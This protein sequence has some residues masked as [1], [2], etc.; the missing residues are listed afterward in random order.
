VHG[1]AWHIRAGDKGAGLPVRSK[2]TDAI[3]GLHWVVLTVFVQLCKHD[4]T[5]LS[6]QPPTPQVPPSVL[7]WLRQ[8]CD[9]SKV[10]HPSLKQFQCGRVHLRIMGTRAQPRFCQNCC[11]Q[12]VLAQTIGHSGNHNGCRSWSLFVSYEGHSSVCLDNVKCTSSI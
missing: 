3:C 5:S 6:Q 7:E 2:R 11:L 9:D 4:I 8:H 12:T 10:M 1:A